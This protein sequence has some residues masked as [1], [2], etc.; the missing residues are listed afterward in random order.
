[1]K[2]KALIRLL[3]ASKWYVIVNNGDD[4]ID[5]SCSGITCTEAHIIIKDLK[6]LIEETEA[7]YSALN[8]AKDII[9]KKQ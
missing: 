6:D 4:R 7:G 9:N 2:L 8:E 3:F 5:R 1:M